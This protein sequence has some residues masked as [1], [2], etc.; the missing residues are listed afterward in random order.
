MPIVGR[1]KSPKFAGRAGRDVAG[2]AYRDTVM[3]QAHIVQDR[4]AG[5]APSRGHWSELRNP[6]RA[7]FPPRRRAIRLRALSSQT[8]HAE[9]EKAHGGQFRAEAIDGAHALQGRRRPAA[10]HAAFMRPTHRTGGSNCYR[11]SA[12]SSPTECVR[13]HRRGFVRKH[14]SAYIDSGLRAASGRGRL[15][16]LHP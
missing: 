5:Y 12:A 3:M 13:L 4:A 8:V 16:L 2:T 11:S 7:I 14:S 15:P 10:R 6:R 9:Q 1:H